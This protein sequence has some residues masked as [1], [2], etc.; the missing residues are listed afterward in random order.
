[1]K[2][3]QVLKEAREVLAICG[4]PPLTE[5]KLARLKLIEQELDTARERFNAEEEERFRR[6]LATAEEDFRAVLGR[7]RE[8]EAALGK[9]LG[10]P[11]EM[12]PVNAPEPAS[13][14]PDI[15]EP[16]RMSEEIRDLLYRD[17]DWKLK[18]ARHRRAAPFDATK[19]YV[20]R[21]PLT[22][23]GHSF[24]A[25]ETVDV[26]GGIHPGVLAR[27]HQHGHIVEAPQW[28]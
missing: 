15:D 3:E 22:L 21:L 25:G 14:D 5:E 20:A 6:V 23:D 16:R 9:R 13:I 8:L 10:I 27:L 18:D 2:I 24:A 19:R 26:P 28:G 4:P 12:F 1:M 7:G 17:A 11:L